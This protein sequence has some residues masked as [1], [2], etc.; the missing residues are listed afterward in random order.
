[1]ATSVVSI[2]NLALQK[3]GQSRVASISEDNSNARHCAACYD[4]LRRA[5]LRKAAWNFSIV[6]A[7]LAPS[8]T[9]P[10]FTYALGFPLPV[11]C[12]RLLIP[13]RLGLDW[14][15]ESLD[16]RPAILTNDGD[17]LYIRYI[18]DVTD[19]T[20]FDPLFEDMLACKMAF[21]M[22]EVLTQSNTKKDALMQ[23]YKDAR[24]E[25]KKM[26]AF[27]KTPEQ[28]PEDPWLASRRQ[29]S[30]SMDRSWAIGS[31]GSEY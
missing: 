17:V 7:T 27:E 2:W 15:I 13:P 3:V 11:D 20:R 23:E 19:P 8:A 9:I 12:L 14:K 22:C 29:G 31:G 30:V 4:K 16:D 28:E 5:E 26:N 6:R 24:N 1:M 10:E 21:N 18:Q 25:A